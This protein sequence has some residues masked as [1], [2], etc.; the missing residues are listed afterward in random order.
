MNKY[1]TTLGI[2][3]TVLVIF[4]LLLFKFWIVAA[5]IAG[6]FLLYFLID[7]F[8]DFLE[9]KGIR[10]FFAYA[11]LALVS[12]IVITSFI[13]FVSIPLV[14]QT[15]ELIIQLPELSEQINQK[16]MEFSEAFP[17]LVDAQE[18]AKQKLITAGKGFFSASKEVVT[19]IL[20]IVFIA[21]ILLA[22]RDTLYQNFTQH[23]PNDYFEVTVGLTHRIV[24]NVKNFTVAKIIETIIVAILYFIGFWAIGLPH[25]L[26]M[27]ILGGILNIIPYVGP[28]I[29]VAPVGIAAILAGG[30][31]LLI[32]AIIVISAVQLIDNTLLQTWLISKF[33]DIHP[34]VV[35]IVTIL[36]E[37]LAGIA[38][39]I[40]AIPVYAVTKIVISGVYDYL[41]S[42]QRHEKILRDEERYQ[43]YNT[44]KNKHKIKT[45]VFS[46]H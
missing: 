6:G 40:I 39:M 15:K 46:A 27:S 21:L 7:S 31:P 22:S 45:H 32:L 43:Q 4:A 25:A 11:V 37:A 2:S 8:L 29:T 24:E 19:S 13:L 38:G 17:F 10:G 14:E 1:A 35:V 9:R 41:K 33:V 18:A 28:L 5:N 23:M 42:V 20:T 12:T 3:I 44:G 36:G 26:L 16:V 30:Y 34:L